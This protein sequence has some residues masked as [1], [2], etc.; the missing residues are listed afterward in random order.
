MGILATSGRMQRAATRALMEIV[1]RI[2][3]SKEK[4][5]ATPRHRA[6]GLALRAGANAAMVSGTLALPPGPLG[7]ITILPDLLAIWRIQRQLVSDIAAAYGKTA[8]LGRTEMIYCLCRHAA[9]H[10]VRGMVVRVGERFLVRRASLP[11]M[12]RMMRRVGVAL[13]ER[14]AGRTVSRWL[15]VVGAVGIGGYAF[16]DTVRVGK[17]ATEFFEKEIVRDGPATV[18][19][20]V[21]DA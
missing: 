5:S 14:V 20:P 2:P 11:A 7:M 15:P 6:R 16:Y 9:G 19:A 4:A 21:P 3:P 10:A 13:T 18:H 1:R 12:Q 17:T 8:Q